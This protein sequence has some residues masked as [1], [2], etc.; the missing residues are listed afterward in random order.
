M[1]FTPD[2][3][4]VCQRRAD[5]SPREHFAPPTSETLISRLCWLPSKSLLL[6]LEHMY[7]K[8][9]SPRSHTALG[10]NWFSKFWEASAHTPW[11]GVSLAVPDSRFW[12]ENMT[13]IHDSGEKTFWRENMTPGRYDLTCLGCIVSRASMVSS[14]GLPPNVSLRNITRGEGFVSLKLTSRSDHDLI[15]T[16]TTTVFPCR[17]LRKMLQVATVLAFGL[18]FE[19]FFNEFC[20]YFDRIFPLPP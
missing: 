16:P 1:I 17:V 20:S 7:S 13:L 12:K 5:F 18:D 15:I 2:I 14:L 11:R 3:G 19:R 9:L 4:G 6:Y 8:V 10:T